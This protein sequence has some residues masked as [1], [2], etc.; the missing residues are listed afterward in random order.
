MTNNFEKL[1][2]FD[3][4]EERTIRILKKFGIEKYHFVTTYGV[5]SLIVDIGLNNY[6]IEPHMYEG[7]MVILKKKISRRGQKHQHERMDIIASFDNDA[8][9]NSIRACSMDNTLIVK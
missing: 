7:K 3:L 4:H 1:Y 2:S 8:I 6:R 9:Y 5:T